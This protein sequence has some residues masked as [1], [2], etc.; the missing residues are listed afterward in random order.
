MSNVIAYL[1]KHKDR[2]VSKRELYSK[3]GVSQYRL[4][5]LDTLPCVG[6]RW[7][8]DGGCTEYRY[9]EVDEDT[10]TAIEAQKQKFDGWET[11]E[12]P[13]AWNNRV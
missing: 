2:W 5:Q 12:S 1:Q 10:Q 7:N 6:K 4:S 8:R 11:D 13:H 9:Y 3:V